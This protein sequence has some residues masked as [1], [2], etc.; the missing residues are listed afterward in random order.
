MDCITRV[1]CGTVWQ[2]PPCPGSPRAVHGPRA[3]PAAAG[4]RSRRLHH[5]RR[6]SRRRPRS[7]TRGM[8]RLPPRSLLR[9]VAECRWLVRSD[10][11]GLERAHDAI[12]EGEVLG[13]VD[14]E[15]PVVHLVGLDGVG[16]A[17]IFE[18]HIVGRVVEHGE[19]SVDVEEDKERGRVHACRVRGAKDA[20]PGADDADH[21]L[22]RVLVGRIRV[23]T[24]RVD[25]SV[26]VLVH[27]GIHRAPMHEAMERRVHHILHEK[28][29][30]E[31]R[32][33]VEGR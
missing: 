15:L 2:I 28:D 20:G 14:C 19:R 21:V 10:G 3:C 4:E 12:P 26:V 6:Q 17:E 33:C 32:E 25:L 27:K 29:D 7:C 24:R 22:N 11:V 1:H 16:E 8:R 30:I 31:C 9:A 18:L 5:P 13:I 23:P